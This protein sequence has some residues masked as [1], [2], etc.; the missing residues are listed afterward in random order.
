ME[1]QQTH[2]SKG[3]KSQ[4]LIIII[5]ALI[6]GI[7]TRI[8]LMILSLN[9]YLSLDPNWTDFALTSLIF[10]PI[11]SLL[12]IFIFRKE[13]YREFSI[14]LFGL[15]TL[16]IPLLLVFE[17]TI[18]I[19]ILCCIIA[20]IF[21]LAA[22]NLVMMPGYLSKI[23]YRGRMIGIFC[24]VA[25]SFLGF[26][27]FLS[28]TLSFVE[29]VS[30][31][32]VSSLCLVIL[33][34]IVFTKQEGFFNLKDS[35]EKDNNYKLFLQYLIP[36]FFVM[37]IVILFGALL[38]QYYPNYLT[39]IYVSIT[40]PQFLPQIVDFTYIYIPILMGIG[41]FVS[42]FIADYLGRR[43]VIIFMI[44]LFFIG[45][46]EITSE[47]LGIPI[48]LNYIIVSLKGLC[49]GIPWFLAFAIGHDLFQ[50]EKAYLIQA[51]ALVTTEMAIGLGFILGPILLP[52][53]STL[54]FPL[55]LTSMGIMAV[56]ILFVGYTKETL[57]AKEEIEW[58][59]SL[60]EFFSIT[61][62]GGICLFHY[63]FL[64]ESPIDPQ[65]FAGGISGVCTLVQE[66]TQS[67][68]RTK[69][70]DQ[71]DKTLILEFG[72]HITCVLLCT[73]SSKI[74]RN[75]LREIVEE[76]EFLFRDELA[77]WTGNIAVFKPI[78]KLIQR[79]FT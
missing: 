1:S 8:Y 72:E 70:I 66:M 64:E 37:V 59:T 43:N 18:S 6:L 20:S 7:G 16:L 48:F 50:K 32:S 23:N 31:L 55:I 12:S 57:P 47:F 11:C 26:L 27:S 61:S 52:Y 35:I 62:K 17:N 54:I 63:N 42:G 78:G 15:L 75:K 67:Q 46:F 51:F 3:N 30:F 9:T 19:F 33:F 71:E 60:H 49:L 53:G 36:I 58:K 10:I 22:P 13:K 45:V 74:L 68:K 24:L 76:I 25:F 44:I 21:G 34:R 14:Y 38:F 29:V 73:A 65:L 2:N 41:G 56:L 79:Y 77:S 28:L 69:V 5:S 39:P 40:P 4:L